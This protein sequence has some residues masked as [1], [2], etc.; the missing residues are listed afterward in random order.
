MTAEKSE[1]LPL[2]R[3][4]PGIKDPEDITGGYIMTIEKFHRIRDKPLA[5]FRTPDGLSIRIKEPTY[6]SR[7]QALYLAGKVTE[8]QHALMAED[9]KSP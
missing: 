8:L 1:T 9:G 2:L 4:Y 6:P 3:Y 7:A 5:G